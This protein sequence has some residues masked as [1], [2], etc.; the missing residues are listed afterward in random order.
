MTDFIEQYPGAMRGLERG[1]CGCRVLSGGVGSVRVVP[2]PSR[3]HDSVVELFRARPELVVEL[4]SGALGYAVPEYAG[5]RLASNDLNDYEPTEYQADAVIILTDPDGNPVLAVIVEAQLRPDPKKR[6]AW[7]AYFGNLQ[8]R[9]QCPV[10]LVVVSP[11]AG[12]VA[13]YAA[14][15]DTGHPDFVLRPL[16]VGPEQLTPITEVTQAQRDLELAVLS[17]LAHRDH[18][19]FQRIFLTL[20]TALDQAKHERA[21]L[22][23]DMVLASCPPAVQQCLEELMTTQTYEYQS[24]FARRYYAQGEARGRTKGRTEGEAKGR[25]EG[26]AKGRAEGEARAVLAILRARGIPV[27]DDIRTR[28]TTCTDLD[29][30]DTWVRRAATATTIHDLLDQET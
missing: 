18:P 29:Q 13:G 21:G 12:P 9:L 24:N 16:V 3:L 2:S 28:I 17:A 6:W 22:Y 23:T 19:Q 4:L 27:P 8:A 30:L 7:P 26:E 11:T 25:T 1:L 10:V 14:P 15:M 5:V 20:A